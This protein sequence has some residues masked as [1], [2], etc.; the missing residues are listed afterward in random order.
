M[1][2]KVVVMIP[3]YN[4]RENIIPLI[5]EILKLNHHYEFQVLIVDDNSPDGTGLIVQEAFTHNPRVKS[6]IRLKRRGRGAAGIDGFKAAVNLQPDFVIEMDGDF[7]HQPQEIPKLLQ[8]TEKAD[9]VIGSRFV[10]E[11]KD[12]ERN[13]L[14]RLITWLVRFYIRRSFKIPVKDVSSGFRCFHRQ[15]LEKLDLDDLI[16]IGPSIVLEILYKAHLLGLKM[17]EV[18]ITFRD[19]AQGKTKLNLAILLETLAM[20]LIIKDRLGNFPTPSPE[21]S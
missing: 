16:S 20:S 9:I 14:R 18:P 11:G 10:K 5:Q 13:L 19:R 7:S 3:T 12:S 17:T 6:L 4:E 1:K 15:A 21:K 8:A 2:K